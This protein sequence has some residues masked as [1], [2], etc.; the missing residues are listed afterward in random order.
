MDIIQKKFVLASFIVMLSGIANSADYFTQGFYVEAVSNFCGIKACE[1]QE[2][3]KTCQNNECGTFTTTSDCGRHWTSWHRVGGGHGNPCPQGCKRVGGALAI[4]YRSVGILP[5][6]P[7]ERNK[8]QCMRDVTAARTC[9]HQAC[10]VEFT[11]NTG[12]V[13]EYRNCAHPAN[14]LQLE[15]WKAAYEDAANQ[16][17]TRAFLDLVKALSDAYDSSE[18]NESARKALEIVRQVIESLGAFPVQNV[19]LFNELTSALQDKA[20]NLSEADITTIV[21]S[22]AY[23]A[24]YSSAP[25][26]TYICATDSDQQ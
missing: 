20:G 8:Y 12:K 21:G 17:S 3:F 26:R 18:I 10:G 1:Q 19:E 13:K 7:Q 24:M 16:S 23:Y 2:I 25:A 14:G 11:R 9:Q 15:A 22:T 5:P 6:T 4:D